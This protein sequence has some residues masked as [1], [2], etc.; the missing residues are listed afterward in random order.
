MQALNAY[1]MFYFILIALKA[2][3]ETFEDFIY[4]CNTRFTN[5]VFF[6]Q[7]RKQIMIAS[8]TQTKSSYRNIVF[9]RLIMK[10]FFDVTLSYHPQISILNLSEDPKLKDS[11]KST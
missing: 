1:K 11:Y 5:P 2:G 10:H 4:I 7:I 3:T 6:N 9:I 8:V